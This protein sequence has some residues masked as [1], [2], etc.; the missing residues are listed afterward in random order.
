M[1]YICQT[2]TYLVFRGCCGICSTLAL[3]GQFRANLLQGTLPDWGSATD[4]VILVLGMTFCSFS[5]T[6]WLMRCEC[7]HKDIV[8]HV[9]KGDA[10]TKRS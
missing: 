8:A 6:E 1:G 9:A 7:C 4:E 5:P 2:S 3:P 10:K